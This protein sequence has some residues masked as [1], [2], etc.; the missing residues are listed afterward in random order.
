MVEFEFYVVMLQFWEDTYVAISK[1]CEGCEDVTCVVPPSS[2]SCSVFLLITAVFS[3]DNSC[4]ACLVCSLQ[5][6][7]CSWPGYE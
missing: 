4:T 7:L 2:L 3:A 5:C 6:A 1:I